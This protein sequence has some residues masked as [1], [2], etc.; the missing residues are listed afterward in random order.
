MA[1][2]LTIKRVSASPSAMIPLD[3]LRSGGPT[4]AKLVDVSKCI[5][6]KGCEVACK[7]WNDLKVEPTANFGSYQSHK[8]LTPNTWLLM[9]FNEIEVDG[10][11]Q[12]LIK[13]D[14]C[15]HCEDPGCLFA[16][17]APGAIV[18]YTNGIVD[19]NQENC[20]GCQYCVTGCPFDIPR[21]D[22]GTRK[23]SKCNMCVDRV[24]AGL[25]PACVK[26]C[27][28]N[29]IAWGSKHDMLALAEKKVETMKA[30]GY[31][32]AAVYNPAGVGGT[33]MMYVVP[34][35]DRLADY[36]LPSDP[37][38]SPAPLT[39]LNFLKRIGA[40]LFSFGMVG[41][42]LHFLRY[43][44]ERLDEHEGHED[45]EDHEDRADGP[46]REAPPSA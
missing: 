39:G 6:C 5:G 25:E 16:C 22:A 45:H 10:N 26:T 30:R 13:K 33:H 29:A 46:A 38:A 24:E 2:T 21:F 32:H 4:Y 42:L 19:F 36:S 23:V 17:P 44:P 27:P 14:A 34:H 15:L 12:W 28:T 3:A 41:T 35:G 1:D 20:I 7:E 18:Q 31:R 11:L 37:T 8:D 40:W 9:R 43:G